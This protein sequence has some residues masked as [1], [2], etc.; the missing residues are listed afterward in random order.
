MN[1]LARKRDAP[2]IDIGNFQQILDFGQQI[3]AAFLNVP[4]IFEI[5]RVVDF[6]EHAAFDDLRKTD[7][8]V[9]R[10]AQLVAHIGQEFRARAQRQLRFQPRFLQR[11]LCQH[12]VVDILHDADIFAFFAAALGVNSQHVPIIFA[13]GMLEFAAEMFRLFAGFAREQFVQAFAVILMHEV[14]KIFRRCMPAHSWP[15]MVS[16]LRE[17]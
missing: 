3:V 2:G 14:C 15:V 10:R 12:A 1:F 5:L 16:K 17:R 4:R 13:V 9:E 11:V 6:S 8:G 7:D